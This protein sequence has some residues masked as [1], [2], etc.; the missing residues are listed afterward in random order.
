MKWNELS[1]VTVSVA[2]L[3]PTLQ[4]K[5]PHMATQIG[6]I[7]N[8]VKHIKS[9]LHGSLGLCWCNLFW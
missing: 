2:F 3:I 8:D 7:S 9:E 4:S 6:Y 1:T 5:A